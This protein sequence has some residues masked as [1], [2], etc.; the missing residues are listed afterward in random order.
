[1]REEKINR[2]YLETLSFSDLVRLADDYGVD[3]PQDLDRRFL[4]AELL[5]LAEES[6]EINNEEMIVDSNAS[7]EPNISLQGNYNETQIT[8]IL[9]NPAWLFVFW[10]LNEN[11]ANKVKE[12]PDSS[13]KLRI[14]SLAN[15]K[16]TV[17]EESFEIQ[18]NN[19]TQE[20]YV[21]LPTGKKY[22]KVELLYV[23]PISGEVLAYSSVI[24]IPQGSAL[25]N[26]IHFDPEIS[27]P[28]IIELSG[29][30][31]ALTEQ[32]KYHRHLFS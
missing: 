27:F 12:N 16:E 1:M 30:R 26:N 8:G 20:Q 3:V 19:E 2:A 24:C 22:I 6:D 17:P 25:V 15:P 7:I 9:R 18:V 5:E 10:N 4:I 23:T 11:D 29:I 14:C 13:F 32:Y 21:L 31:N 28:P